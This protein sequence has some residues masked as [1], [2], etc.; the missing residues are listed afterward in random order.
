MLVEVEYTHAALFIRGQLLIPILERSEC[1]RNFD[2]P[3]ELEL[4][5]Q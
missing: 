3:T 5:R 2:L 4:N 1:R